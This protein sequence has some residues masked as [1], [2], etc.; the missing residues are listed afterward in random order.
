MSRLTTTSTQKKNESVQSKVGKA[1]TSDLKSRG[2]A[3][4]QV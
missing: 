2:E 1:S 3:S 4:S